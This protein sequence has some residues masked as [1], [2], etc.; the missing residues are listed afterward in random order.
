VAKAEKG[1][2]LVSKKTSGDPMIFDYEGVS[3]IISDLSGR[4]AEP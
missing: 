3:E 4:G 2:Q 1:T